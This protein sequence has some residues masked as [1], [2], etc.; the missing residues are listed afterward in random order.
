MTTLALRQPSRFNAAAALVIVAIVAMLA[1]GG[2]YLATRS[3]STTAPAAGT[4]GAGQAAMDRMRH[5]AQHQMAL[6]FQSLQK[7]H[8]G[9]SYFQQMEAPVLRSWPLTAGV[10]QRGG[11]QLN[12]ERHNPVERGG[13]RV[14]Q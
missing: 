10:A 1:I 13:R 3:T 6:R 7:A 4:I 12:D 2:T 9:P 5:E 11:A 14:A 8:P